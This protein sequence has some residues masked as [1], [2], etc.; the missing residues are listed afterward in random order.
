MFGPARSLDLHVLGAP[1][2]FILSWDQTLLVLN[3]IR[4]VTLL[5]GDRGVSPI[6]KENTLTTLS[7][8]QRPGNLEV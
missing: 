2:A 5:F 7:T 1:L 3:L 8:F 6:Q 4:I